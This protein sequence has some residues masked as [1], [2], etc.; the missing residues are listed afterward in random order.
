MRRTSVGVCLTTC[1]S[2]RLLLRVH[3]DVRRGLHR[4]LVRTIPVRVAEQEEAVGDQRVLPVPALG[5]DGEQ[6]LLDDVLA[7]APRELLQ[8]VDARDAALTL[9]ALEDDRCV[10]LAHGGR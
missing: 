10:V 9:R 8:T 3:R 2:A 6:P 5:A 1:K 4:E 7:V